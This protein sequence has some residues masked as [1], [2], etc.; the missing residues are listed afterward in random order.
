MV[1]VLGRAGIVVDGVYLHALYNAAGRSGL[2]V[3]DCCV[4]LLL[5]YK[6]SDLRMW[7]FIRR[8]KLGRT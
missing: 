7:S 2:Y 5:F 4:N 1:W 6:R 3:T 8:A